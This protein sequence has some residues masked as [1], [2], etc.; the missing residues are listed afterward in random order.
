MKQAIPLSDFLFMKLSSR[1]HYIPRFL[2]NGFTNAEG[3]L[4]VYDKKKDE[5]GKRQRSPKSVFFEIE[6]NTI[7]LDKSIKSSVVEDQFYSNLDNT[8]SQVIKMLQTEELEKINF[9]VENTSMVLFFMI[10]LFWRIPKTDYA[11]KDLMDRSTITS[12]GM[13][14]ETLR[15]DPVYRILNRPGIFKHHVDEIRKF[16]I[17][18]TKWYNIFHN[19]MPV[20]VIGDYPI[21]FKEQPNEFRKFDESDILF[22]VSSNRI[23]SSTLVKFGTFPVV[24]SFRY[25]A[26][27]I[28]Q[29]VR[30][31]AAGDL[32]VLEQSVAYYKKLMEAGLIYSTEIVFD[33][34]L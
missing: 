21:L 20:Y 5:I 31:V 6:R 9:D 23:Y 19:N 24:N 2:I 25:N 22:A 27:V 16:G 14:P 15:N 29:S 3:M 8:T 7:E 1:H 11:F 17:K 32:K 28:S 12:D 10:N 18:G 34:K 26:A 13:D 30:Y 33:V 4:Y